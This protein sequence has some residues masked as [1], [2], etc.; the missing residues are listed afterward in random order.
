MSNLEHWQQV[1]TTKSTEQVGWYTPHLQTSVKWITELN[2]APEDPI[3]DVGGGASMLVDDLIDTGHTEI[4]VLDMSERALAVVRER[5]GHKA[6][7]V[8]WLQADVTEVELPSRHF[9]LWHDRAV[10]HFLVEPEQQRKYLGK[11]S[12]ALKAGGYFLIGAFDL[13]APAKCSGLPVQRYSVE[14]L[15]A[16]FGTEFQLRRQHKEIHYTPS[17]LEQAYVYCLFQRSP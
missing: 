2:L 16:M 8:S 13:K 3:I 5:L 9:T 6:E 4:S 15:E 12:G 14:L 10:F 7:Q 1:Y 11:L 17:G